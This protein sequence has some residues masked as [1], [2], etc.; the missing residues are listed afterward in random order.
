MRFLKLSSLAVLAFAA[1]ACQTDDGGSSI[2]QV[3]PLAYVRYVN[4]VP[5]S[6]VTTI[7]AIRPIP[8]T[9]DTTDRDTTFADRRFTT[10]LRWTDYLEFSPN[11]WANIGFRGIGQGGYQGL[12]AGTRSF[13]IF[14]HD[15]NFFVTAE[16]ADTT[17]NFVAGNFYTIVH[18]DAG[19]GQEQVRILTD[20]VPAANTGFQ[21]K[22]TH[23]ANGVGAVDVYDVAALSGTNAG[24]AVA[25]GITALGSSAYQNVALAASRGVQI[26]A[27]GD[28]NTVAN[29]LATAG[30]PLASRLQVQAGSN[31]AGSVMTA[32]AFR[33]VPAITAF[34]RERQAAIAASIVWGIDLAPTAVV[35]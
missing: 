5:D 27:T 9:P 11:Q 17:F 3:P 12:K 23:L 4:A 19:A 10:T 16:R 1:G 24:S 28:V 26:T 21:Y 14:T 25:T 33:P 2:T 13:K 32:F 31:A 22:F 20:A 18:W 15:Q 29:A 30:G 34:G 35:P 6:L 8:T 7:T